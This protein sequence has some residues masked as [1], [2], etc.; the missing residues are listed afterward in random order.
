MLPHRVGLFRGQ[1]IW[2]KPLFDHS[3]WRWTLG[4]VLFFVFVKYHAHIVWRFKNHDVIVRSSVA[5]L[6]RQWLWWAVDV[7]RFG[8]TRDFLHELGVVKQHPV[9]HVHLVHEVGVEVLG[10]LRVLVFDQAGLV[11]PHRPLVHT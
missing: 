8:L 7:K 10:V 3:E 2:E 11:H 5:G 9:G 1:W 6:W 4:W